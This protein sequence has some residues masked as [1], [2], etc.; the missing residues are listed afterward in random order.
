M[1]N[2][3]K[4]GF[5]PAVS[6]YGIFISKPGRDVSDTST[7]Y[8]LDSRYRTLMLHANGQVGMTSYS[9]VAG[10]TI[11]YAEVSFP[12]LGYRPVFFGNIK[13]DSANPANIPVNS[14]GVPISLCGTYGQ[15]GSGGQVFLES[16]VWLFNNT[17]L[18][19]RAVMDVSGSGGS[20]TM[21]WMVFKNRFGE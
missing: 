9:G 3:I 2:R 21:T 11:W 19:G 10:K 17:T 14:A 7:N 16:G 8:L 12:D 5:N 20:M 18:R 1:A 4:I 13:Y 15:V 6:D